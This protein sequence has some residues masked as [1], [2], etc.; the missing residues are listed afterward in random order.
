MD[1]QKYWEVIGKIIAPDSTG[2]GPDYPSHGSDRERLKFRHG[3][4]PRLV[5]V[6]VVDKDGESIGTAFIPSFDEFTHELRLLRSA[7]VAKGTAADLGDLEHLD[8]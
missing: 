7:L 4:D 5:A 6:A 1:L 3:G 8:V 2:H